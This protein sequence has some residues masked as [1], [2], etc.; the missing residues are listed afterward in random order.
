MSVSG[1]PWLPC[2]PACAAPPTCDAPSALSPRGMASSKRRTPLLPLRSPLLTPRVL[3]D[4][5]T[6]PPAA[7]DPFSTAGF[8]WSPRRS[9]AWTLA[10]PTTCTS[11]RYRFSISRQGPPLTHATV[12][13]LTGEHPSSSLPP[14][15]SRISLCRSSRRPRPAPPSGIAENLPAPPPWPWSRLPC[16]CSTMGH[17]PKG[18][19][20]LS[21]AGRIGPRVNSSLY[22]FLIYLFESISNLVQTQWNS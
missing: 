4:A 9:P 1:R 13:G 21:W 7:E 2:H 17:Q 19:R 3:R 22:S 14:N 15:G 8:T 12:D 5:T 6:Q 10:P 18:G 20:Q 16:L 11:C